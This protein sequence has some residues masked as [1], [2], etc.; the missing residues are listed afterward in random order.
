MQTPEF[1]LRQNLAAEINKFCELAHDKADE[2]I[3]YA[4]Q[5]GKL[6]LEAKGA[7]PHGDWLPWL[8]ANVWVS[9]RQAQRYMQIAQ[10]RPLPARK[11][12]VAIQAVVSDEHRRSKTQ[13]SSVTSTA[14]TTPVSHLDAFRAPRL[15]P[16]VP[17]K[18]DFMPAPLRAYA[19]L[20]PDGTMFVVEPSLRYPGY[21]FVSRLNTDSDTY[22]CTRRPI[23]AQWVEGNLQYFGLER[24]A[25]ADW[26]ECVCR[27]V[28]EPLESLGVSA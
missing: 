21:C 4:M 14:K 19:A 9:P 28:G 24:P 1:N 26:R 12:A 17:E 25:D 20:M 13:Q 15:M 23:G 10:G 22:D 7:L 3:N 11:V 18:I 16:G 5:A 8:E 6:L 27:G 2:A